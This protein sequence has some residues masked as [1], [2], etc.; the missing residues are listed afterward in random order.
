MPGLSEGLIFS[1]STHRRAIGVVP[2]AMQ[3]DFMR[4]A[5]WRSVSRE[6]RERRARLQYTARTWCLAT[7]LYANCIN[8][9]SHCDM[10][11]AGI[12][13]YSHSVIVQWQS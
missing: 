13:F 9:D 3:R 7:L 5:R 2:E 6:K 4:A 12:F 11:S 8:V 1:I 10:G